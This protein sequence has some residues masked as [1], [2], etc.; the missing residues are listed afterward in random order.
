MLSYTMKIAMY[1]LACP[2]YPQYILNDVAHINTHSGQVK[3]S[4]P[5]TMPIQ[6]GVYT[7]RASITKAVTTKVVQ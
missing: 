1:A 3:A 7:H 4:C 6:H 2:N 5:Q